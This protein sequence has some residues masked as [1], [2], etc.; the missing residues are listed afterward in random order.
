MI[1][2]YSIDNVRDFNLKHIFECGQC[3]RWTEEED[4]SFTGIAMGRPVNMSFCKGRLTVEN[5]T[6]KEFDSVWRTYLDLDRDYGEIKRKLS[7]CDSKMEEAVKTGNGIRILHQDLWE[8]IISFIISQN[9]NI[10]RIRGCIETLSELYGDCAGEYRGRM[11][12]N[13]P[14]PEKL[15]ALSVD[16]LAPVRLGYRAR[17][18]TGTAKQ[19]VDKGLPEN[20]EELLALPGVGPKVANCIE[21]FGMGKMDSFPVDVW[22]QRVMHEVYGIEESH[23]KEMKKYA[24]EHFGELGGIA[25]QYLFYYIREKNK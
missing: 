11:W 17:Y 14:S 13:L 22:V 7:K 18:L 3:F 5:C 10:P 16:D 4:G 1:K 21:L 8:M 6:E 23:K 12:Y 19:V 2:K 24:K 9:N 25:Q 15:A 20:E